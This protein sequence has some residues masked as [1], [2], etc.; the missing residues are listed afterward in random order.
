MKI[1]DSFLKESTTYGNVPYSKEWLDEV[2]KKKYL[3]NGAYWIY[4]G[5]TG[6]A[7]SNGQNYVEMP[8]AVAVWNTYHPNDR[9]SVADK[10]LIHHKNEN[11]HDNSPGNLIKKDKTEHDRDHLTKRRKEMPRKFGHASAVKGGKAAHQND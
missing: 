6:G 7:N 4:A 11:K 10:D 3:S 2:S 8:L 9:V 5:K 1:I